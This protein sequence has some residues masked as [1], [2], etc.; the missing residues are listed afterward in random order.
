MNLEFFFGLT[1]AVALGVYIGTHP[2]IIEDFFQLSGYIILAIVGVSLTLIAIILIPDL[3]NKYPLLVWFFW[4]LYFI[5]LIYSNRKKR[6]ENPEKYRVDLDLMKRSTKTGL[7]IFGYTTILVFGIT[8][9]YYVSL[10][11]SKR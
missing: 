4:I 5:Y 6:K 1:V 2:K 8:I 11:I 10:L 3:F 9:I 7:I